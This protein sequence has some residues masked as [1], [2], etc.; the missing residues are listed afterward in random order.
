MREEETPIGEEGKKRA[1]GEHG[2]LARS[3]TLVVYIDRVL[4]TG[5]GA[6]GVTAR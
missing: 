3:A 5:T 1:R 4:A 6:P 2:V